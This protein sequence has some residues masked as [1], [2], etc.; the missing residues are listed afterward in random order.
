[1]HRE[2]YG[3]LKTK[4]LVAE[5]IIYRQDLEIETPPGV[6]DWHT[7]GGLNAFH[8]QVFHRKIVLMS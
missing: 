1:M 5:E 8:N 7:K 2:I 4:I 3:L 6:G